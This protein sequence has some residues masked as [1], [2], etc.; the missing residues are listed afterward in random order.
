MSQ[1]VLGLLTLTYQMVWDRQRHPVAVLL[2]VDNA[3]A[4][5]GTTPQAVDGAHLLGALAQ[6]WSEQSPTLILSPRERTLLLDLLQHALPNGPWIAVHDTELADPTVL[7]ATQRAHERGM[8]LVWRGEQGQRADD[9]VAVHFARCMVS[10][11][12]GTAHHAAPA[13][14]APAGPFK[15]GQIF[16]PAGS[17]VLAEQCL[18]DHQAW[19]VAGWPS[20]D[21]LKGYHGQQIQPSRRNLDKLLQL[22]DQ[23]APLEALEHGLDDDPVLVYRF[24]RY[25]NSAALGLRSPVESLRHGLMLQGMSRFHDWLA[26]QLPQASDDLNLEPVRATM[27]LRARLMQQ[28]L[29]AGEEDK[30]RQ[31]AYLCGLLSRIDLLLGESITSALERL[32]LPVAVGEAIL[33]NSGPFAPYLEVAAALEHPPA[34]SVAELCETHG[35]DVGDVNR[36]LLR[37][38]AH[39]QGGQAWAVAGFQ[40]SRAFR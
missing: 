22:A 20:D 8:K 39:A 6:V 40:N 4:S 25:F 17:R 36:A 33:S 13:T 3:A 26:E 27:V 2:T 24:L 23:D 35:L 7:A 32:A 37:V 38:L 21:V 31:A 19:G 34:K 16:N 12:A 28:L 14:D 10:P 9:T 30:L 11:V 1:S 18:E 29:D 15:P 5:A